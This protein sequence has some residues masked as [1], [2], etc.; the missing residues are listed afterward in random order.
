LT[1]LSFIDVRDDI[2]KRLQK[3]LSKKK[4]RRRT[5]SQQ[6]GGLLCLLFVLVIQHPRRKFAPTYS[7]DGL[8]LICH[9]LASN[10][11][12]IPHVQFEEFDKD[13]SGRI[14]QREF[15]SALASMEFNLTTEVCLYLLLTCC[16]VVCCDQ[17]NNGIAP[18]AQEVE[19]LMAHF[20]HHSNGTID[21]QQFMDF[22]TGDKQGRSVHSLCF[23]WEHCC[24]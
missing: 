17:S 7:H 24:P 13:A 6:V 20:D 2:S 3:N 5:L 11:Y 1:H 12:D 16:W 15:Q 4:S 14:T 19:A 23:Y 22:A 18:F 10:F 8:A 21:Y 9:T